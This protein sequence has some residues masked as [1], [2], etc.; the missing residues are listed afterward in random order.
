MPTHSRRPLRA[1]AAFA[2]VPSLLAV[3]ACSSAASRSAAEPAA[4]TN[5]T[6]SF[7][8]HGAG[9]KLDRAVT[10]FLNVAKPADAGTQQGARAAAIEGREELAPGATARDVVARFAALLAKHGWVADRD[11]VA[12]DNSLHF[13]GIHSIA[14][15]ASDAQLGVHGTTNSEQV[16]FGDAA[17]RAR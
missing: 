2:L 15:G 17:P 3:A 9:G 10:A 5:A 12:V 4:P 11:F 8:V 14:G 7:V 1:I 6:V 13:Y 16:P